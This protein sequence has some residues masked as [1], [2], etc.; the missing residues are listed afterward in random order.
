MKRAVFEIKQNPSGSYYF[1]LKS[2][3]EF[4]RVISCNYPDRAGLEKCLASIRDTAAFAADCN[5]DTP[6]YPCF[7]MKR[8]RDGV[9][10]SLIGFDGEILFTSEPYPDRTQ[11]GQAIGSIK[12]SA[13][14]AGILDLTED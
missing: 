5:C 3:D 1:I 12:A 7:K 10:F 11:C 4:V 14:R 13:Q 8:G 9:A 6:I 2:S